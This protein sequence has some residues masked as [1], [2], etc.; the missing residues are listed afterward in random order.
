MLRSALTQYNDDVAPSLMLTSL[1]TN[2][3][4]LYFVICPHQA[5]ANT[6]LLLFQ[7]LQFGTCV[8]YYL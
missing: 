2:N 1:K 8:Y 3:N 5:M 7:G 4:L 6:Y